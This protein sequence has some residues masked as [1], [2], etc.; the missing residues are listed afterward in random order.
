VRRALEAGLPSLVVA[1]I[2]TE[3]ARVWWDGLTSQER[4]K[5]G[6][7]LRH[8]GGAAFKAEAYR[9]AMAEA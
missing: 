5:W 9:R 1:E 2:D 4:S 8:I 6:K 3:E 7:R